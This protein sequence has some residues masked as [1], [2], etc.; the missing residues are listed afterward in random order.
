MDR[1]TVAATAALLDTDPVAFADRVAAEV[2]TLKGELEVGTFDNPRALLGLEYEF[3]GADAST[4]SLRRVPGR[5]LDLLG[6]EVELGAHNAEFTANP[7]PFGPHGLR[8]VRSEV[9]AAVRTA[10]GCQ[11][12][13]IR[14][15]SDGHWTLPPVGETAADYLLASECHD[16]HRFATNLTDSPRY[17]AMSNSPHYRPAMSLDAPHAALGAGT[18]APSSL[19]T[20]IQPHYQVPVAADLPTYFRYALRIAGPLLAL[21][22]NSPFHPPSCY[23]DGATVDDVLAAGWRESRVRA[24]ES[25]MND[26]DRT[27]KVRF[28]RD[29]DSTAEAVER[30]AADPVLVPALYDRGDDPAFPD[31]FTHLAHK[32]GSYWRWVRPVFGAPSTAAANTR[33]EFRPLPAQPTVRDSVAFLAAV[34]GALRGLVDGDHPVADLPWERARE[35]FYAAARDGLDADLRWV[36]ADGEPT[37][38]TERL[39]ADLLDTARAGLR[40]AGLSE[41]AAER[42]LRPLERRVETRTTPASWKRDRLRAHA[43]D[44]LGTAVVRAK[45]D[46]LDRQH[47][48]LVEGLFTDWFEA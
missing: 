41:A 45:R 7:Q 43:G 3:Y 29:L 30:L 4:G 19:T 5:L 35:N 38:E 20:T 15:V 26:P 34:G 2:E 12:E 39:F 8:A 46:Y 10:V 36:T 18:V 23:A 9:Q 25:V 31:R 33:I 40:A 42:Y 24:F 44:G 13:Q 27:D 21:A 48:T 28:P 17:H 11:R 6:F 22:V 14:L 47:G 32:H 16:G 1:E 37:G